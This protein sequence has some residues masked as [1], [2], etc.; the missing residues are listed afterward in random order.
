MVE[1][2]RWHT[3]MHVDS[4]VNYLLGRHKYTRDVSYLG[5]IE[6]PKKSSHKHLE[7][8]GF[9]YWVYSVSVNDAVSY[10]KHGQCTVW[11]GSFVF[12]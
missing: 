7:R 1:V 3:N 5:S 2:K 6:R 12:C 8:N 4:S 10:E 9:S 11:A